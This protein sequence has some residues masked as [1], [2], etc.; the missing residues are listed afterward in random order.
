MP[1]RI[2][3]NIKHLLLRVSGLRTTLQ[4]S[5]RR[6]I[7]L[8]QAH[9]A[10]HG[11]DSLFFYACCAV[12]KPSIGLDPTK[13]LQLRQALSSLAAWKGLQFMPCAVGKPRPNAS[14]DAYSMLVKSSLP[15]GITAR[16]GEL[17]TGRQVYYSGERCQLDSCRSPELIHARLGRW[18]CRRHGI[19]RS[20]SLSLLLSE[21]ALYATRSWRQGHRYHP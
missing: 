16:L 9:N 20:R 21:A 17:C 19:R 12:P 15:I 7:T 3:A 6:N 5:H 13:V 1:Q 14:S 8:L 10:S 11:S 18:A 4:S 2:C